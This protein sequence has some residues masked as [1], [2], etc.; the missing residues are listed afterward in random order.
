M[1]TKRIMQ[2]LQSIFKVFWK[3]HTTNLCLLVMS[4]FESRRI[5]IAALG[6]NLRVATTPKH[7]IKRV[8]RFLSNPRFDDR[9][10]AEVLL[11]SVIGPRRR[12]LIAVDWTK[13][14]KWPA[15]VA[16]V[17]QRGRG[18]PILWAVMDWR[19]AYKSQNAFENAFFTW[20]KSAL[21]EGVKGVVLLDRGFKRVDLIKH[22]T[23]CKLS[24]VIRRGGNVH[25]RHDAYNGRMDE[26]ISC[27]GQ[28]RD[29][30]KA[31]LRPSRPVQVR[32][33]GKWGKGHKEPWYLQTDLNQSVE[34]VM[35]MYAKRFRIEETF[36]DEKD[37][38]FGWALGQLK[39]TQARRLERILLVVAISHFLVMLVGGEARR[40]GLARGFRANTVRH[41]PTHSDFT[42]GVYYITRIQWWYRKLLEEF[43]IERVPLFTFQEE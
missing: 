37:T 12:V 30:H 23:R 13:F 1:T 14:R 17:I 21:P 5:G 11:R 40:R 43:Y 31:I 26:L 42:L 10:A 34:Q 15:L 35:A 32:I 4:V 7:A 36:R 33:L 6:R 16:A 38:R 9:E 3:R 18:I 19:S 28:T 27:R 2:T 24:F 22:L 41:K 25:I 20:L 8:D 29:L 39:I